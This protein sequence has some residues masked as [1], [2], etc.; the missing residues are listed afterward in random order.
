[1]DDLQLK[2]IIAGLHDGLLDTLR[3]LVHDKA[4]T[5]FPISIVT[6]AIELSFRAQRQEK[7]AGTKRKRGSDLSYV[8]APLE[9]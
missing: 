2:T 4:T 9:K 1:M 5:R 6:R 3:T 8:E 7:G